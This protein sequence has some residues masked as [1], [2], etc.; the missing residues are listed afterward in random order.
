MCNNI[1][2]H[3]CLHLI[4]NLHRTLSILRRIENLFNF[5]P[6]PR[7]LLPLIYTFKHLYSSPFLLLL[8][9]LLLLL[10]RSIHPSFQE[11]VN[12]EMLLTKCLLFA[13]IVF[14][15]IT[16]QSLSSLK[17][18]LSMKLMHASRVSTD[19]NKCYQ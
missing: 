14:D 11:Q 8:R 5:V 16:T 10:H 19:K 7:P 9:R 15:E 1:F 13:V 12:N 17:K 18:K 3:L 2:P 6:H 4:F